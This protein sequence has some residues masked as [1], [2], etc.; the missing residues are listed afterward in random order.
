L[1]APLPALPAPYLRAILALPDDDGPRLCAADWWDEQGAAGRAEFVRVQCE[2]AR[3]DPCDDPGRCIYGPESPPEVEGELVHFCGQMVCLERH[4]LRRRERELW[5]AG[6]DTDGRGWFAGCGLEGYVIYLVPSTDNMTAVVR[7][8]FV[9]ELTAPAADFLRHADA[10][11]AACPLRRVRLTTRPRLL[12]GE[13]VYR[14]QSGGSGGYVRS[15]TWDVLAEGEL[16]RFNL[17]VTISGRECRRDGEAHL[18]YGEAHL[19]SVF[20]ARVSGART[21]EGYFKARWPGIDF[22]MPAVEFRPG[23]LS[24]L[25]LPLTTDGGPALA[26]P[27]NLIRV[28]LL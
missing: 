7:R 3:P 27:R 11:T 25:Q 17:Q 13:V 23:S 15:A 12:F 20:E 14:N 21:V 8:G 9:E 18:L 22:E 28:A 19:L 1:T 6:G 16:R 4:A 5:R 24:P 2:L 26:N 10:L